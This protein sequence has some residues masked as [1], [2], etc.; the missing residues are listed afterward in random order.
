MARVAKAGRAAVK[1]EATA[2]YQSALAALP[3]D[4]ISF[5]PGREI[6]ID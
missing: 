3:N 2:I 5:E 6:A 4:F 1:P